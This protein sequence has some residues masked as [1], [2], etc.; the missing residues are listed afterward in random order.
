MPTHRDAIGCGHA[1]VR[2]RDDVVGL[3][4]ERVAHVPATF[5]G[6]AAQLAD[7]EL[8]GV[9]VVVAD[10]RWVVEL[11]DDVVP[12]RANVEVESPV[13]VVRVQVAGAAVLRA[14]K[15]EARPDR[16]V[17]VQPPL[18]DLGF[19]KA[20]R[21]FGKSAAAVGGKPA[22][23]GCMTVSCN[24][25]GC[26]ECRVSAKMDGVNLGACRTWGASAAN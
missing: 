7:L 9:P 18:A 1:V 3:A 5:V 25:D 22:S 26:G 10:A 17:R 15:A 13:N 6:G 21:Q 20:A 4:A 12:R 8:L 23:K 24:L 2:S 19:G 14:G 16:A 11:L